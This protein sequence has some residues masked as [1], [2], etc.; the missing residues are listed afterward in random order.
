M[1]ACAVLTLAATLLAAAPP[2]RRQRIYIPVWAAGEGKVEAQ[3]LAAKLNGEKARV[4][5]V[6]A[7]GEDLLLVV[8]LDVTGDLATVDPAREALVAEIAKLPDNS[9]VAV[10]RAQDGLS[11]VLDPSSDRAAIGEAIRGVPSTGKAGL[12]ETVEDVEQVADAVLTKYRVRASVLYVT[13]S[14]ISNYR[15]DFTNPVINSS[16]SSDLSRRFPEGLIQDKINRLAA[17][18]STRQAPLFIVH[19]EYRSDRLNEAYQIGLKKLAEATAGT[20]EFCRSLADIPP[21]LDAAFRKIVSHYT[22]AIEL[23]MKPKKVLEIGLAETGKEK[24][25]LSYRTRV[26]WKQE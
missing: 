5:D 10:M 7:P 11:V 18:V 6:R 13:D 15:E 4:V 20:A 19:L 24:S 2:Q 23:P 1:R 21:S 12:L 17:R 22:V 3:T 8:V 9:R 14:D 26:A 25:S 16:D